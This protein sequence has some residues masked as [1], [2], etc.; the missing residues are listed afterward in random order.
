[1]PGPRCRLRGAGHTHFCLDVTILCPSAR[2]PGAGSAGLRRDS[3]HM[4][5]K[6]SW[7]PLS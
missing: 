6:G 2:K 7:W 3:A 1:M 4:E 5:A